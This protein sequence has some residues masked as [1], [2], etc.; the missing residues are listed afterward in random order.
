MNSK[1]AHTLCFGLLLML[2]LSCSAQAQKIGFVNIP[3]ILGQHPRV[4]AVNETLRSEFAERE[5]QLQ[6]DAA[7]LQ[8]KAE[9]FQRDAATMGESERVST[10]TALTAEDRELNRRAT[11]FQEDVQIRQNELGQQLQREI[12]EQ[13]QSY[14]EEAGYDLVVAD[15]IFVSEDYDI[16]SEVFDAITDD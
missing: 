2:G 11:A 15:A 10:E 7:A 8:E 14:V 13:I 6:A 4:Q 12:A 9:R 5:S 16:T 3:Y 1:R